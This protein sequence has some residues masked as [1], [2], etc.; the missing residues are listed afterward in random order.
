MY[1]KVKHQRDLYNF[2]QIFQ[3]VKNPILL[4]CLIHCSF[5]DLHEADHHGLD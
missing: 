3:N 1:L 4:R 5:S 2:S